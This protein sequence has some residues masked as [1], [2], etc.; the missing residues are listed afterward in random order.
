VWGYELDSSVLGLG[1][2]TGFYDN[3]NEASGSRVGREFSD[4]LSDFYPLKK[5][6]A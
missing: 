2:L 3:S 4:Y 1:P 5:N 6:C